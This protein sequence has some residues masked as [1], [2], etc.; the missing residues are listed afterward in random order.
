V[1]LLALAVAA[2][3]AA[4]SIPAAAQ[5]RPATLAGVIRGADR[6]PLQGARLLAVCGETG[7]IA[8]SEPTAEDG[9]FTLDGLSAGS[10]ELAVASGDTLFLV[11]RSIHLVAGVTRRLEVAVAPPDAGAV[12]ASRD[13]L[14]MSWRNNPLVAAFIVFGAAIAVGILVES[15]TEDEAD[16]TQSNP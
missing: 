11:E 6:A 2:S 13:E 14:P 8:S 16:S 10:W 12:A 3:L 5:A 7:E 4:P 15:A 1:R 9:N